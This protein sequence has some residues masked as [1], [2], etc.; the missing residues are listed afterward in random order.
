MEIMK[1][2]ELSIKLAES[3]ELVARAL[4]PNGN[5]SAGE[6]VAGSVNGEEGKSLKV[7]LSGAM[8][9]VWCD[10]ATGEKGDLLDLA[11]ATKN[12]NLSA[13]MIWA[14]GFLGITE[15]RPEERKPKE[16]KPPARPKTAKK[17]ESAKP[18]FDYL[19][20]RGLETKTLIDF[21][22]AGD[23]EAVF[24]PF[25]EQGGNL[26]MLKRLAIKRV[27][28]KKDI[29]PTSKDQK[30]ILF[31]WQ[32]LPEKT[33]S[34]VICEGE[35]NAMSISQMGFPALSV[36]FGAGKG[37]KQ[38]WV[39]NE[40]ENLERFD[41]IYLWFDQ[42]KAGKEAI[43]ELVARLGRERCRIIESKQDANEIL[44]TTG[45]M[46]DLAKDSKETKPS[47]LVLFS[48]I[49]DQVLEY[50][51]N[52][53]KM[54]GTL[55]L[56]WPNLKNDFRFRES[57]VTILTGI[58]S[59]GKTAAVGQMVQWLMARHNTKVCVAGLEGPTERM[60]GDIMTQNFLGNPPADLTPT[61]NWFNESLFA[62]KPKD[63]ATKKDIF[64][65][66]RY[67][68]RKYGV[69]FFVIDNLSAMSLAIDDH[70]GQRRFMVE[71]IQFATLEEAHIVLV[72]H[73]RKPFT[74]AKP[75]NKF[76]VKGSGALTDLADNVFVWWRNRAK[77][78][79]KRDGDQSKTDEPD[80]TLHC[81]KQRA[82]GK[83]FRTKLWFYSGLGK[84]FLNN[85]SGDLPKG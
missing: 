42:D 34:I 13:A 78:A 31:G 73:M 6:W 12:I 75:G 29:R 80:A 60:I 47:S 76:D 3:A 9:G 41:E 57:E 5:K 77:E 83:E 16:V 15:A 67:C 66:F 2:K 55:T 33:R 1:A 40:Y 56:P 69:K 62:Y 54:L 17:I 28:G 71:L 39:E 68:R 36:P 23:S 46:D 43:P 25:Y 20:S 85:P 19:T 50:M 14:K 11:C 84:I 48:D 10:F 79:A 44:C 22:I 52:P 45:S 59:H 27:N 37:N 38:D 4:L 21:K 64:D 51:R 7:H 18:A 72:T 81:E 26:A 32:A 74:D 61:F 82:T 24:F 8:A 30:K 35:I 53:E 63:R 70:D 49:K 65:V 58:N